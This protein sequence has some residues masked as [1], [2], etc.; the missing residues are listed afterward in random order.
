MYCT[1]CGGELAADANFCTSCGRRVRRGYAEFPAEGIDEVSTAPC[2]PAGAEQLASETTTQSKYSI[3]GAP[4]HSPPSVRPQFGDAA[5]DNTA[6]TAPLRVFE[7]RPPL[8][9]WLVA[10]CLEMITVGFF[11]LR[12]AVTV[13]TVS[14]RAAVT[15]FAFGSL[16]LVSGICLLTRRTWA[17]VWAKASLLLWPFVNLSV[18]VA[19]DSDRIISS[20]AGS[21]IWSTIGVMYLI[22]SKRVRAIYST[23]DG[24]EDGDEDDQEALETK[25]QNE[26]SERTTPSR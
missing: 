7:T 6:A 2:L 14:G 20:A 12:Q 26:D 3:P 21:I 22:Q 10:L 1:Q 4:E 5:P 24:P 23:D 8:G 19:F 11:F 17:P 13:S 25:P 18:G 9:A 15:I 16:M